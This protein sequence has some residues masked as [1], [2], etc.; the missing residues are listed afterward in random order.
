MPEERGRQ[1][2]P[3]WSGTIS[4]GLVSV[5]VNLFPAQRGD[6]VPLRL[7]DPEGRPL[8]RRYYCPAEETELGGDEIVRGYEVEEGKY[9]VIRDEE[10]EA[11]EP[12]KTRDIDLRRFVD[13]AEIDPMFF[14]RA[15]FLT[16]GADSTKAYRLL[17]AALEETDRA[18]IATFVMRGKEYWVAILAEEGLLAAATLRFP[19]EIRSPEESDCRRRRARAARTSSVSR[20]RSP[21]SPPRSSTR[22]SSRIATPRACAAWPRRRNVRGRTSWSRS[23]APGRRSARWT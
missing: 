9:V 5:P 12:E 17:A 16:P 21:A 3:F 10:L 8:A 19:A 14:D 4:F 7:L 2:R 15:Y 13:R 22:R 23:P 6:G 18:G 1:P 20:R 11:L